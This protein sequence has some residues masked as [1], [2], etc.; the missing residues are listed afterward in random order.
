MIIKLTKNQAE[1]LSAT[2]Q[3][4]IY[5]LSKSRGIKFADKDDKEFNQIFDTVR[6]QYGQQTIDIDFSDRFIENWMPAVFNEVFKPISKIRKG[7]AKEMARLY[8]SLNNGEFP[9]TFLKNYSK[10]YDDIG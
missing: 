1:Q 8:M 5:N 4:E 9:E 6:E 2:L 7:N 10:Y 3:T